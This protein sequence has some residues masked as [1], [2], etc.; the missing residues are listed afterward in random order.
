LIR[1]LSPLIDIPAGRYRL[2]SDEHY[3][4]ERPLREVE[5]A[6]C[7]IDRTPVT[8]RSFEEFVATT[9]YVTVAERRDAPGSAVFVMSTS[10]V[11]LHDPSKWWRF[12]PG[13]TWR[14]PRGPGSS[15]ADRADHPVIH[16]ALADA[17]AY[18]AWCERRLPTESEWEVAARGGLVDAP[19]AWGA[20]L[21]PNGALMANIW[22][23]A[24]PWYFARAG[25]PGT[26]PVGTFPPNGFGLSDMIGNVWE[27]TTSPFMR[28]MEAACACGPPH[29][30]SSADERITLKGGSYL[31]A[32]E[33]C[34]RYRPAARI[35]LTRNSTTAHVGFRCAAK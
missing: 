21:S 27:W 9:G 8:N 33:Y 13:A 28:S 24:F 6:R 15:I 29:A 17:E 30:R 3:P 11:D 12:C 23:G 18:A 31:C 22:T 10:P 4:E 16:M 7:R 35:G 20:E 19:Y 25:E 5:I 2:G 26:T 1:N 34:A 32:G 14:N